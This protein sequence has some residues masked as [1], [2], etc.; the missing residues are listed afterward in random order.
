MLVLKELMNL[1]GLV[2]LIGLVALVFSIIAVVGGGCG[3]SF[4]DYKQ[5][6]GSR[7]DKCENN[8]ECCGNLKCS[9]YEHN[10]NTCI[11]PCNQNPPYNDDC[12]TCCTT[13][14]G[15]CCPCKINPDCKY[16]IG[17]KCKNC[18]KLINK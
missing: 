3:S 17:E 11:E 7:G 8:N 16:F 5:K 9:K 13:K 4:G 14:A 18:F 6:C 2:L 10:K 12:S 1:K 15:L